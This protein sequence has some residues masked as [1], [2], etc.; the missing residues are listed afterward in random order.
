MLIIFIDCLQV[1]IE[2]LRQAG[3]TCLKDIWASFTGRPEEVDFLFTCLRLICDNNFETQQNAIKACPWPETDI[4]ATI[5]EIFEIIEKSDY[6]DRLG[7]LTFQ[8]I[9]ETAELNRATI[10]CMEKM[11]SVVEMIDQRNTSKLTRVVEELS[12]FMKRV[13]RMF[14]FVFIYCV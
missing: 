14:A 13:R 8:F 3:A 6:K 11:I 10:Y 5:D 12:N 4:M 2:E 1:K 9:E 7:S